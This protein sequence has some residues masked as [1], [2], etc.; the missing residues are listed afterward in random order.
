MKGRNAMKITLNTSPKNVEMANYILS[1]AIKQL[2]GHP[3]KLGI[4]GRDVESAEKFRRSLLKAFL[5][6]DKKGGGE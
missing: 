6:P 2:D 4:S 5:H 3:E 1:Q